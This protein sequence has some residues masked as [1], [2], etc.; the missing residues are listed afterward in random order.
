MG[1]GA[2]ANLLVNKQRRQHDTQLPP[3]HNRPLKTSNKNHL[4]VLVLSPAQDPIVAQQGTRMQLAKYVTCPKFLFLKRII[5]TPKN[6]FAQSSSQKASNTKQSATQTERAISQKYDQKKHH[7]T[8]LTKPIAKPATPLLKLA[9]ATGVCRLE[10]V[11]S[12][13]CAT[14]TA[15]SA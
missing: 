15:S 8:H 14:R 9:I 11:P 4:A 6:Q 2:V 13:I 3:A 7:K 5:T 1:R 10:V 12:P